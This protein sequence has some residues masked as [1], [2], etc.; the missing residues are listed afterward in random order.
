[1][2]DFL[3]FCRIRIIFQVSILILGKEGR[4]ALP[5]RRTSSLFSKMLHVLVCLRLPTQHARKYE[6]QLGNHEL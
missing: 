5:A 1:M 2:P 4:K 3:A 6:A